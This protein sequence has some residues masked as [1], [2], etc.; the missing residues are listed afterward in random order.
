MNVWRGVVIE[1]SLSDKSLLDEVKIVATK[2]SRLE[3]ENRVLTFHSIKVDDAFKDEYVE[4]VKK[5]IKDRFYAH[6]CKDHNMIVIFH[7]KV[8]TFT[9]ND[10]QLKE[11]REYGKSIEIIAEQ[12]PFEHLINNPFD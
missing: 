10:P 11:A 4:E 9:K 12:M 1:E 7:N 2:I 8:F 6:L 3:K 5:Y